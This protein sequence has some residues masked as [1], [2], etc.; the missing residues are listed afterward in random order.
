MRSSPDL[1][2]D[3]A[4]FQMSVLNNQFPH[5]PRL[6]SPGSMDNQLS[7][8]QEE[9]N[10]IEEAVAHSKKLQQHPEQEVTTLVDVTDG[11]ID[12]MYFAAGWLHQMG[13]PFDQTWALIHNAN[14]KKLA[15]RTARGQDN[16]AFKPDGWVD[17]KVA[18]RA[19]ILE[20]RK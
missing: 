15:G 3:I 11:I 20:L 10:E 13:I 4:Q 14:M 7:R 18:L 2:K 16:D 1:Q 5:K 8:L 9:V 12:L 17:P 6:L 19:M